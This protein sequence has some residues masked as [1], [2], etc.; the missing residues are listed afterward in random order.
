MDKICLNLYKQNHFRHHIIVF[1]GKVHAHT[2]IV[3][4]DIDTLNGLKACPLFKGLT[5][6]EIISLMHQVHYRVQEYKKGDLLALAGDPCHHV[7][8]VVSG[9]MS[10][11]IYGPSGRVIR[12]DLHHSGQMLAPAFLFVKDGQYPVAI[13]AVCVSRVLRMGVADMQT[14]LSLDSRIAM[15]LI[16]ILSNNIS[17]LTKKVGLLS[18]T[19]KEKV[20]NYIKTEMKRQGTGKIVVALSRQQLADELGIQKYSLQRC[21]HELQD[22][23]VIRIDGRRIDVVAIGML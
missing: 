6:N 11:K 13:E 7:N 18:M 22:E 16:A 12:L 5:E 15:N 8:I 17:F 23:G 10:A 4:M 3:I 9:E 2:N 20:G 14:M 19:V 21:L 1:R